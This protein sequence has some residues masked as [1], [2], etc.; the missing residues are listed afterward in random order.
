MFASSPS[1]STKEQQP[2]RGITSKSFLVQTQGIAILHS[3]RNVQS[4]SATRIVEVLLERN[5]CLSFCKKE[6]DLVWACTGSLE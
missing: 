1:F 4:Q 3:F 6:V 2:Q 5:G